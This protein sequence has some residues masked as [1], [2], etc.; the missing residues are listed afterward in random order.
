MKMCDHCVKSKEIDMKEFKKSLNSVDEEIND[1]NE[2][3]K[4]RKETQHYKIA[5]LTHKQGQCVLI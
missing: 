5:S 1:L 3:N 4:R 2:D